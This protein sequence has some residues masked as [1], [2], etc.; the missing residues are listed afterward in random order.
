MGELWRNWNREVKGERIDQKHIVQVYKIP[1]NK[2]VI[3]AV[4][5]LTPGS[6][7]IIGK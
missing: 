2:N 7:K 4:H 1:N 6:Y 3:R 5:D